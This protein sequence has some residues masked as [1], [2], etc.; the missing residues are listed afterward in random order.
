MG[1]AVMR[2]FLV[3]LGALAAGAILEVHASL[4]ASPQPSPHRSAVGLGPHSTMEEIC[5]GTLPGVSW[6]WHMRAAEVG[7]LEAQ[8]LILLD[9]I[10]S[11]EMK[12]A[13]SLTAAWVYTNELAENATLEETQRNWLRSCL[14]NNR[15]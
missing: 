7:H 4:H 8:R 9:P 1:D 14:R 10:L 11:P 6:A 5:A 12:E 13:T 3:F 15:I 2:F